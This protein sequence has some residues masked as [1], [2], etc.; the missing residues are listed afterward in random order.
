MYDRDRLSAAV[1][2][3]YLFG[4]NQCLTQFFSAFGV[5]PSFDP[6][7]LTLEIQSFVFYLPYTTAAAG[8][9]DIL[10]VRFVTRFPFFLFATFVMLT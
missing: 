9:T 2:E 4:S 5:H 1:F 6:S 10:D 8:S 3:V 7:L